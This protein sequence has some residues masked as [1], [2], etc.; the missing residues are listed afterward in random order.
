MD[1]YLNGEQLLSDSVNYIGLNDSTC[2]RK[3]VDFI[4]PELSADDVIEIR[5]NNPHKFGNI[6]A[7]NEL[8]GNIYCGPKNIFD[9]IMLKT[10]KASRIICTVVIAAAIALLASAMFFRLLHIDGCVTLEDLGALYNYQRS[11]S[12]S[13]IM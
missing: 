11:W 6:N 2:G 9:R 3:W 10:G 13:S 4:S 1:I 8:L 7:C 12:T 5:L